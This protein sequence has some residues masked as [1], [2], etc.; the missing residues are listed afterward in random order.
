MK[1]NSIR[2]FQVIISSL[3]L[4]Y[5]III[6]KDDFSL[7]LFKILN[8][9]YL[10]LS[11]IIV[12]FILPYIG[13]NRWKYFLKLIGINENFLLLYKISVI[14][15]FYGLFLPSN[16][17]FLAFK[18]YFIEKLNPEKIGKGGSTI[19]F[20]KISGLIIMC[21]MGIIGSFLVDIPKIWTIRAIII[22]ISIILFS[23]ILIIK[24]KPTIF[25]NLSNKFK[26]KYL[27][28]LA[29]YFNKLY[30]AI[31]EFPFLKAFVNSFP[32]IV[33][34]QLCTILNVYILFNVFGVNVPFLYNLAI[35]PIIYIVT[36]IP[37]SISGLGVREGL[38]V[39]FFGLVGVEPSVA[40][41]VS[42]SNYLILSVTPAIIGG[43]LSIFSPVIKKEVAQMRSANE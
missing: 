34:F 30:K 29:S 32:L 13:V 41:V 27:Q 28:K 37:V 9:S 14:S 3:L 33:I 35:L 12:I 5:L 2:I 15:D 16:S 40:L 22:S 26:N 38:F 21:I 39:Y 24:F 10:F 36:L 11:A 17:G 31:S 8:P 25:E 19:I 18:I 23:I 20:S 1:K 42:L 6:F 4:T 7:T 43:I